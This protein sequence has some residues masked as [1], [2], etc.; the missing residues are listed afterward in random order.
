[1]RLWL[2]GPRLFNVL[3][4]PGISLGRVDLLAWRRPPSCRRKKCLPAMRRSIVADRMLTVLRRLEK[5]GMVVKHG[6]SRDAQ[7]A[8]AIAGS[9]SVWTQRIAPPGDGAIAVRRNAVRVIE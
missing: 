1:M 6:T 7:W 9:G 2:S 5:R 3:V 4:R 8:L